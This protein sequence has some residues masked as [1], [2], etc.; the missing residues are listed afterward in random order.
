MRVRERGDQFRRLVRSAF[1]D[2]LDQENPIGRLALTQVLVTA[3]D[4]VFAVSLAGSLFFSIS[5]HA[6]QGRVLLYLLLTM[7]PF[8]VV[9]PALGPLVDRSRGARRA[10]VVTS[11]V[12]RA[13]LSLLLTSGVHSLLLFPEAF[14]MLVLSKV[15][16][17]T[18]GALVP[19]MAKLADQ[20]STGSDRVPPRGPTT[21]DPDSTAPPNGAAVPSTP[22]TPRSSSS[23]LTTDYASINARLGLLASL[24]GFVAALPAI[25]ILKL[26]GASWV[27]AFDILV[28]TGAAVAGWRLPVRAA[29]RAGN[30]APASRAPARDAPSRAGPVPSAG[31]GPSPS[32][33]TGAAGQTA[34]WRVVPPGWTL[35]EWQADQADLAV[36]RPI[37]GPEVTRARVP[38]SILKVVAGFLTFLIA[39]GLRRQGAST[40]WFGLL[41]GAVTAGALAG[42]VSM[43]RL[44]Q[45]ASEQQILLGSLLVA[46]GGAVFGAAV[47]DRW[48]QVVVALSVGVAGSVAKPSFD[49]LAQQGVEPADQGRAFARFE[50]GYQLMWVIGAFAPVV[51]DLGIPV[52]DVVIAVL[53]G[54]GALTYLAYLGSSRRGEPPSAVSRARA[55]AGPLR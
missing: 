5:P 41:L 19:E 21:G 23:V 20:R 48:A 8:A 29:R 32:T 53:T 13:V 52:G 18:K 38:M 16:L 26:G 54:V 36:F 45:S 44:R 55:P 10:T 3:G 9:A 40:W 47:G 24:S 39:F 30:R 27:L 49:A 28:F 17:V 46:A 50:T 6:A 31:P 4:T 51:L 2:L 42:V 34:P 43:R 11:A 22:G 33:V 1:A 14:A 25:A 12:G 7:A 35:E 37:A 15:Y